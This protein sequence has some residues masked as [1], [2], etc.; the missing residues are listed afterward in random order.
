MSAEKRAVEIE[1]AVEPRTANERSVVA[2]AKLMG[3]IIRDPK[4]FIGDEQLVSA[5]K[6]QSRLGSFSRPSEGV[7]ATSRCTI[8]R[9]SQRL[10][11]GGFKWFN[12]ERQKALNELQAATVEIARPNRRTKRAVIGQLERAEI[13]RVQSLVDCWQI[14][15]AFHESLKRARALANL[16]RSAALVERWDKEEQAL[17]AMF[18]LAKRPVVRK[19]SEAE[20]W[21]KKLRF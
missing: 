3:Q 16:S 7:H 8:E 14:T 11:P 6:R 21:L 20:E 9:A 5:F 10:F 1:L 2:L 13:E 17:L 4:E 12:D 18:S 15:N 19:T